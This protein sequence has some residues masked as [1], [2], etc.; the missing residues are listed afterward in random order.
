MQHAWE[1]GAN[2]NILKQMT[3]MDNMDIYL[4]GE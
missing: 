2:K 3:L 4:K 1:G